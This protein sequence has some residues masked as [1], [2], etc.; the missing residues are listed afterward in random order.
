M[1]DKDFMNSR[2]PYVEDVD[3]EEDATLIGLTPSG[4]ECTPVQDD[5]TPG[6]PEVTAREDDKVLASDKPGMHGDD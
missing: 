4:S 2:R 6:S 1:S 5:K 3:D